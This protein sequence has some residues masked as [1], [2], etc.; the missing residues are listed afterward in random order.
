M[1]AV[2]LIQNKLFLC[3]TLKLKLLNRRLYTLR[4]TEN[5]LYGM[6]RSRHDKRGC[7]SGKNIN[8]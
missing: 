7:V 1:L 4:L 2:A 6:A 3:L 8:E 5:V